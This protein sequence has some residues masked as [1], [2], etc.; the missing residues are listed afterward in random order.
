MKN[1]G[2]FFVLKKVYGN[3]F[4]ESRVDRKQNTSLVLRIRS[5]NEA[6]YMFGVRS[7]PLSGSNAIDATISVHTYVNVTLYYTVIT[8]RR[9]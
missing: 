6:Y 4:L 9:K 7:N 2:K 1:G 8:A 5:S 3:S